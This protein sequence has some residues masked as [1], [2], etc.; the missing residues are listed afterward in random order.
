MPNVVAWT[1]TTGGLSSQKAKKIGFVHCTRSP[2]GG[3]PE[4]IANV[5]GRRSLNVLHSSL[6]GTSISVNS[7]TG[8]NVK[9]MHALHALNAS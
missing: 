1:N 5:T 3:A 8:F 9:N 7:F 6:S 4:A 2:G